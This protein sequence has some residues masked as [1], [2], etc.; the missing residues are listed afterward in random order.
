MTRFIGFRPK[1]IPVGLY[2]FDIWFFV[3]Q[4]KVNDFRQLV[5][6]FYDSF[7]G[8]HAPAVAGV[9]AGE[10]V[11]GAYGAPGALGEHVAERLVAAAGNAADDIVP[12]G[13]IGI[14]H[15]SDEGAEGLGRGK[16]GQVAA[17]EQ[18]RR[19]RKGAYSGYRA[20]QGVIAA[21]AVGGH[22]L[23]K[24]AVGLC[25]LGHIGLDVLDHHGQCG[26]HEGFVGPGRFLEPFKKALGPIGRC[27]LL[28]YRYAVDMEIVAQARF[29]PF[30]VG[31]LGASE[32]DEVPVVQTPLRRDVHA[33]EL[34]GR[35]GPRY[36][37]GV[38]RVGLAHALLVGLRYVG[39][40]EDDVVYAQLFE[41]IVYRAA[42]HPG[43]VGRAV[44]H[45]RVVL[46]QVRQEN[47]RAGCLL[48]WFALDTALDDG[49]CPL[50]QVYIQTDVHILWI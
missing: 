37:P 31:Y 27:E 25:P 21:V 1:E 20:Q 47:R 23:D 18:D 30:Q 42:A 33:A 38:D 32:A 22:Q 7:C 8:R 26:A 29:V 49:D 15:Q 3:F 4:C 12:V 44:V 46:L 10:V 17:L 45:A 28:G 40:V 6:Y 13:Q 16:V 41:S 14:G 35:E 39:R 24:Q 36:F 9:E 50:F 48:E 5:R 19:G 43:L 11:V 2:G 34:A